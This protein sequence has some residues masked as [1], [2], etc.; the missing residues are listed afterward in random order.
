VT[1]P[2]TE[3]VPSATGPL[4]WA[5]A[6]GE[7]VLFTGKGGVG[8]STMA[9]AVALALADAGRRVLLV[10]TDPASNLH[11]LLGCPV[12]TEPTLVPDA[13][14]LA[15]VNIDPEAAA[16]AYRARV[17]DPLRDTVDAAELSTIEEQLAG[18]C[19]TEV[20]AFDEFGALLAQPSA[21]RGFDHVVFDT[22]PTGH[23]LRL[24]ALAAEW[25]QYLKTSPQGASCLGPMGQ[26]EL[27]QHR[28][29]A[30]VSALQDRRRTTVVLVARPDPASLREAAR[31]SGELARLGIGHQRLVI[32]G[33]L[34]DPLPVDRIA[35]DF[36]D[37]QR[38]ALAS[39]PEGLTDLPL[40]TLA[41]LPF[42]LT[43]T[44]ALRALTR[45]TSPAASPT[46]PR[47]DQRPDL[48]PLDDLVSDLARRG[49][50]VVMVMGKGGVGKTSIARAIAQGL[51]SHGCR[52]HLS[53]TDPAGNLDNLA[54]GSSGQLTTSRIDPTT[55]VR[56]YVQHRLDAAASLPTDERALLEEDLRSPCTEEIAVFNAFSRLLRA[57][58]DHHVVID[59]APSGHT[60]LLLDR[61]GSY[62]HD[63][64][65][66]STVDPSKIRTPL[67]RLQDPAFT[68]V[69]L[70]TLPE[71]TPVHEAADLQSDLRRAG[72][73]PYGWV[74]NASLA[75]SGTQDPTLRR[76]AELEVPLLETI[77]RHLAPRTWIVP[78][79]V[80]G[81]TVRSSW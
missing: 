59:T 80:G 69:L 3:P 64:L 18:Q 48:A 67:M 33:L 8:K 15:A 39:L 43:G 19:T 27:N 46:P 29:E 76:R 25:S 11:D 32:N 41:L 71:T 40:T 73:E 35:T 66:T 4:G 68:T 2:A 34:T 10:S 63:V 51:A 30:A 81:S 75:A 36:A 52:T 55:E 37:R 16:H 79:Q 21:E 61:T 47:M 26:L 28:Y 6:S 78:W 42:D 70:V 50:G 1:V 44:A 60:L 17:L 72:I 58:R 5:S 14:G 9:S 45:E 13:P 23:T 65:R 24:L 62:H 22:A 12:G 20:A 7:F 77:D 57:G 54:P 56:R 53:T 49:P 38:R 74:I 31:A